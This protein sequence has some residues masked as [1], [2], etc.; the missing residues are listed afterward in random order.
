MTDHAATTAF[1]DF[2][3]TLEG[4]DR[5]VFLGSVPFF[6]A[7]VGGADGSYDMQEM[8]AS[9]EVLLRTVSVLGAD[10]R[11]SPEAETAF[12]AMREWVNDPDKLEFHGRLMTLRDILRDMPPA[13]ADDYRAFVRDACLR[14]ANASGGWLRRINDDERAVLHRVAVALE[15]AADDPLLRALGEGRDRP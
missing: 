7:L 2:A 13:L 9:A 1:E 3:A 11:R 14:V 6:L 4:R 8:D 15:F 12:A 10:F 5:E